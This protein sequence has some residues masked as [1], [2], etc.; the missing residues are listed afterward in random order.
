MC[1]ISY[2]TSAYLIMSLH[3]C[4]CI[5]KADFGHTEEEIQVP[6]SVAVVSIL[7]KGESWKIQNWSHRSMYT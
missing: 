4:D 6:A 2:K 3:C 5:W 7:A 1:N